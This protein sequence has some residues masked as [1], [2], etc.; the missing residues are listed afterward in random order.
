MNKNIKYLIL[1]LSVAGLSLAITYFSA[2]NWL[3]GVII[4]VF[5]VLACWVFNKILKNPF[6]GF[7]ILV[8]FL[9]FER[10][11]SLDVGMLTIKINQILALMT[12]TAWVLKM[13]FCKEKIVYNPLTWPIIIFLLVCFISIFQAGNIERAIQVFIFTL[14]MAMISFLTVNMVNQTDKLKLAVRIIFFS[15]LVVCLFALYQFFGDLIGLGQGLTGLKEG[16]TKATFGFPRMMAFANEPLYLANF[17]FIPLGMTIALF[18]QK[19]KFIKPSYLFTLL[20]LVLIV[21]VL[22]VSRGAYLG[23][24]AMMVFFLIFKFRKVFTWKNILIGLV[25]F[26]IVASSTVYFLMKA[27]PQAYEEFVKHVTVEDI[28]A[29][30]SIYGRLDSFQKAIQIWQENPILGIGM[31]NYGPYVKN[32]PDAENVPGW[33]IVNN[34]YLEILAESGYL[35]L[36]TFIIIFI[37]LIW[38]FFIVFYRSKDAFLKTIL[39]G[40]MAALLAIM[41]QYN[42]FSTIY[43]MHIWFLIGLIIAVQNLC[44]KKEKI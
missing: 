34:E 44:L 6:W 21:F 23:L 31:G 14:F 9:P 32:F 19:I 33:D 43:I 28:I 7:L 16:Y 17:L 35:G 42:T 20:A 2:E 40:L 41:V 12:L 11:P 3:M 5:L 13:L 27:E 26:S 39:V 4:A 25:T 37:V 36:I 10:I 15:T 24:A 18:L 22:T 29:G 30:E 8:F 38:R 1:A